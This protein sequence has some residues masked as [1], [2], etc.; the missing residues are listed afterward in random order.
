M[1]EVNATVHTITEE[2]S[3]GLFITTQ[4]EA[5]ISC[6]A[7]I[8]LSEATLTQYNTKKINMDGTISYFTDTV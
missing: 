1:V 2:P 3:A 4:T 7:I 6:D 5:V 8:G